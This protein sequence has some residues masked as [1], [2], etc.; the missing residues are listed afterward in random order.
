M[1]AGSTHYNVISLHL[2]GSCVV[3]TQCTIWRF[4]FRQ[5]RN[6]LGI[7]IP[8]H[9]YF[10]HYMV[11]KQESWWCRIRWNDIVLQ[12]YVITVT[13]DVLCTAKGMVK[14]VLSVQCIMPMNHLLRYTHLLFFNIVDSRYSYL[15]LHLFYHTL[16]YILTH[17]SSDVVHKCSISGNDSRNL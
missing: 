12:H 15:L 6:P 4:F 7:I 3:R 5:R 16:M 2:S 13:L 8:G 14:G 1:H 17:F 11:T 10:L 9:H